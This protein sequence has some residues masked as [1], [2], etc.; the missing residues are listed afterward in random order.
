M[1]EVF[2][3]QEGRRNRD[4]LEIVHRILEVAS[5]GARKTRI[6]YE[7]SL[8]YEQ[9]R[10]YISKLIQAGLLY[11]DPSTERYQTTDKGMQYIRAYVMFAEIARRN[12]ARRQNVQITMQAM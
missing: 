11:Q 1:V 3:Q 9:L 10:R 4:S 7:A 6:M 2:P 12:L 8:G 5:Y